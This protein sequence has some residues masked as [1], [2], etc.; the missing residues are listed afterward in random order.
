MSR[1]ERRRKE[2]AGSGNPPLIG[3]TELIAAGFLIAGVFAVIGVILLAGSG[4]DDDNG[5]AV[6]GSPTNAA[7]TPTPGPP[8]TGAPADVEAIEE[9]A[10]QSIELLP[11]GQWPSL[12]DDFVAEFQARCTLEEFTAAGEEGAAAQ[13]TDLPN[14]RYVRMEPLTTAGTD[15]RGIIVGEITGKTEYRI[16]TYFR[17]EAAVWKIAPAPGTTGCSAF[18]RV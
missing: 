18:N 17:Q 6:Q 8:F 7:P 5:E 10:R 16:E 12:Y 4:D 3:R 13:G 15:V 9:L 11:A 1:Q 14:L 2:R